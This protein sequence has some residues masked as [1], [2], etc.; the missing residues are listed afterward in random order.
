MRRFLPALAIFGAL[1][2][3]PALAQKHCAAPADQAAFEVQALRSHLMVLATGCS[4]SD[5]YNAF[6][7]R[8][9]ADLVANDQAV[10]GWF[11]RRYGG[12]G[13]AEHDRFITDLANAVSNGHSVLGG[14][15]CPRDGLMF[16]EVLTLRGSGDLP[17]YAAAK[18][19]VPA[20]V[21]ICAGQPAGGA[22]PAVKASTKKR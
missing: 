17:H 2:A 22:K 15:V 1:A 3:Q 5:R 11:K 19:L 16:A 20:S 8:Y 4:E 14:D 13:Q 10:T 18:D 7:R 12:R 9:Q 6:V 21:E